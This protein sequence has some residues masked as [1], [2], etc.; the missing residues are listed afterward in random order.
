[1][2][3]TVLL[4]WRWGKEELADAAVN[5]NAELCAGAY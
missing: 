2:I 5:R 4:R 1:M 3:E